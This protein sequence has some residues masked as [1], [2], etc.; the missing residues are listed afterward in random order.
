M[1]NLSQ[2]FIIASSYK[3]PETSGLQWFLPSSPSTVSGSLEFAKQSIT[4][5]IKYEESSDFAVG[6]G[7]FTIEWFQWKQP[8]YEFSRIFSIGTYPEAK[9]AVSIEGGT[10]YFWMNG[11]VILTAAISEFPDYTQTW[12]HIAITR[13]NLDLISIYFDGQRV[14]STTSSESVTDIQ[15]PLTIG[16]EDVVT[17]GA[18]YRGY[19]TDF[20]WVT[21]E[22]LY[23]GET[24]QIPTSP[25][26]STLNSK[27]LLN[28]NS[29][30][31][32]FTDSSPSNRVPSEVSSVTWSSYGPY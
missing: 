21:G 27:L 18:Q 11:G 2:A 10:L 22:S 3:Y 25:I 26:Q 28:A 23:S 5:F 8:E 13:D 7:P 12:K 6:S 24:L 30:Q 15:S 32:E 29:L 31:T 17:T 1:I 9:I 19:L 4:S 14:A 16:N 20:H